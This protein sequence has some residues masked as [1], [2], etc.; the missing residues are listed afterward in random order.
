MNCKLFSVCGA[1]FGLIFSASAF[2]STLSGA[3]AYKDANDKIVVKTG[4]IEFDEQDVSR[5]KLKIQDGGE[6]MAAKAKIKKFET[7]NRTIVVAAF[8]D[9][10]QLP[11]GTALIVKASVIEGTNGKVL[12]GDIYTRSCEQGFAAQSTDEDSA[13]ERLM[14]AIRERKGCEMNYRGGILLSAV[15][16][17]SQ[18]DQ[19]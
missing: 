12:Y 3:L 19:Q 11:E 16:S 17:Q 13:L 10:A 9:V 15:P 18:G 4:K 14:L 8:R 6:Q 5:I 1:A 7:E 2:A